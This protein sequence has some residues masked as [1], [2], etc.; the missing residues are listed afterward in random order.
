MDNL[1]SAVVMEG[2]TVHSSSPTIAQREFDEFVLSTWKALVTMETKQ[3]GV[4]PSLHLFCRFD[5]SV[6]PVEKESTQ[7]GYFVNEVERSLTISLWLSQ[8]SDYAHSNDLLD[9]LVMK[10][11]EGLHSWIGRN[12]MTDV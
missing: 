12:S 10:F 4:I 11:G 7:L 9:K 8:Q 6:M 3:H 2:G 5:V 1:D